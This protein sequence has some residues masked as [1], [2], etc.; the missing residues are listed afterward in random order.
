M[1]AGFVAGGG[2]GCQLK[3]LK[4]VLTGK[5]GFPGSLIENTALKHQRQAV[6]RLSGSRVNAA[7]N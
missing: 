1:A 7:T 2:V 6:N 3:H 5:I 4:P